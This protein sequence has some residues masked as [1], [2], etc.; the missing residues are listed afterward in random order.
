MTVSTS[1]PEHAASARLALFALCGE[2]IIAIDAMAIHEIR[3]AE[4]ATARATERGLALELDG[5][6]L[7]AWDLGELLGVGACTAAWVIVG[8][9]G[10]ARPV[11]FRIG[12][13]VMV[14]ALP[15]CRGI[16]RAIFNRRHDA[17]TAAFST[18]AIPELADHASGVVV[19]LTRV[20]GDDE[21]ARAAALDREGREAAVQA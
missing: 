19:D 4:D 5:A 8:L 2:I 12:R 21:R 18:A 1:F 11:G 7:P 10:F 6:I 13:C 16:P 20:L 9:P 14:Q 17:I 15:V 3:R